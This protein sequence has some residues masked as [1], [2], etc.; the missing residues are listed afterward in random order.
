MGARQIVS[1]VLQRSFVQGLFFTCTPDNLT[2]RIQVRNTMETNLLPFFRERYKVAIDKYDTEKHQEALAELSELLMDTHLPLLYR[3]KA[4]MALAEG[5][6]DWFLAEDYRLDAERVYAHIRTQLDCPVGDTSWPEQE[7]ELV[8]LR[9]RLDTL[10]QD[11]IIDDPSSQDDVLVPEQP[12][13]KTSVE[14]ASSRFSVAVPSVFSDT[15]DLRSEDTMT[16]VPTR[17]RSDML[18]QQRSQ[19]LD[20]TPPSSPLVTRVVHTPS[21]VRRR[22][23][24]KEED[25][26]G[27][28][29][30]RRSSSEKE[31][32]F[33]GSPSKK[34][35]GG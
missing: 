15:T 28:P 7:R 21:T 10:A 12:P 11:Q 2:L 14:P 29:S 24:E 23:S 3:L 31:K 1:R 5:H 35:K 30:V 27:S 4:N 33:L 32:Y 34:R 17:A 6:E 25:F 9:E 19:S 22:S 18:G 26:Y 13:Q 8:A 16:T 20:Y